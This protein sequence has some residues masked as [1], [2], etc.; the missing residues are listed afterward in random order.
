MLLLD[1]RIISIEITICI[2]I[3]HIVLQYFF[4]C[5]VKKS[6]IKL[7]T[8]PYVL[9]YNDTKETKKKK[10]KI[11]KIKNKII[12][13]KILVSKKYNLTGKPDL[14]YKN[15][16]TG[17]MIPVELKSSYPD[18]DLFNMGDLVQLFAYFIILNDYFGKKPRCGLLIYPRHML[19]IRN[20]K[21]FRNIVVSILKQMRSI[22][23][24]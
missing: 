1:A 18:N 2:I 3:L 16:F 13:S 20:K 6:H 8:W 23:T 9:F 14:I 10:T 22:I 21:K 11:K 24:T 4:C 5:D 7:P 19:I 17:K 15:I 12:E